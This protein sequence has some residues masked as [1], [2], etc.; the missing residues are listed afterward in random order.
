MM[1]YWKVTLHCSTPVFVGS[2]DILE[3]T[4]FIYDGQQRKIYFL[5]EKKW[6]I[7]LGKHKWIDDFAH[8]LLTMR[9]SYSLSEY[10]KGKFETVGKAISV[11]QKEG[12]ITKEEFCAMGKNG[13]SNI[14]MFVR[15]IEGNPYIP[16][17][18]LKGAFRTAILASALK[19]G[20]YREYW[21]RIEEAATEKTADKIETKINECMHDLEK[22]LT[23]P[24]NVKKP[25]EMVNSYFRGLQ[26]GDAVLKKGKLSI[27]QKLDLSVGEKDPH[28]LVKVCREA[29]ASGAELEFIL[30]ID[31]SDKGMGHFG[32][33]DFNDLQ[34]ILKDFVERQYEILKIPFEKQSEAAKEALEDIYQANQADLLLGGGTGFISKTL[35]YMLAPDKQCAVN[36]IRQYM[37]KKFPN[38]K[39]DGDKIIAP[40]T[41]KL[42]KEGRQVYLIGCCWLEGEPLC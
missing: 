24:D 34:D 19:K 5:D 25:Q 33:Q 22:A 21:N 8:A 18:S 23:I 17:S 2:G 11:L 41:L 28:K 3:K 12:V 37:E 42:V 35:I 30:G 39:H 20:T 10:V 1:K 14:M 13:P 9:K 16:G 15:D 26:V 38:G 7:F 6:A 32:I 27:V 36:V 4:Q 29:L 40:H 31:D